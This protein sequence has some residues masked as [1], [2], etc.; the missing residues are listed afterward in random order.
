MVL[1]YARLR[2]SMSNCWGSN[3]SGLLPNRWAT[4]SPLSQK[5]MNAPCHNR[6]WIRKWIPQNTRMEH[7]I[8]LWF[9]F[10]AFISCYQVDG[11]QHCSVSK[12]GNDCAQL[13][14]RTYLP[15]A[16]HINHNMV[17]TRLFFPQSWTVSL[18]SDLSQQTDWKKFHQVPWS[19]SS[20]TLIPFSIVLAMLH[21]CS[22]PTNM[23]HL[24]SYSTSISRKSP[25]RTTT[26]AIHT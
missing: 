25:Q 14:P 9:T 22:H 17:S 12:R 2:A 11:R 8:T 24:S 21:L 19:T 20:V 7:T 13:F 6:V 16:P 15:D 1:P 5:G 18:S 3:L 10:S 23:S 4:S 26:S